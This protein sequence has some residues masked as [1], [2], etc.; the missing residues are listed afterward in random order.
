MI[1]IHATMVAL[2]AVAALFASLVTP[3]ATRPL[4]RIN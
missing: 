1:A 2:V 3:S 4:Q